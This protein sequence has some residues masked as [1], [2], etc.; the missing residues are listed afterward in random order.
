[1]RRIL[2][3]ALLGLISVLA[4]GQPEHLSVEDRNDEN[5]G[6]DLVVA[7][8]PGH[9]VGA[10]RGLAFTSDGKRLVSAGED[11]TVQVWDVETGKRLKVLRPPAS[12]SQGGVI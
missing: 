10:I 3:L 4:G 1:M 6:K 5:P 7:L 2:S 8:D 9:H 12:G 11:R